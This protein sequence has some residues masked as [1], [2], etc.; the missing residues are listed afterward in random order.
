M[1]EYVEKVLVPYIN[2]KRTELRFSPDQPALLMFDYFKAQTTSSML[3][4]LYSYNLYVVLLPANCRDRLQPLDL[5]V[6]KATKD[7]LCSKSGMLSS[8]IHSYKRGQ[9]HKQ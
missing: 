8:C 2:S 6:N 7:L 9:K 1:K 4:L 3:K 5:S